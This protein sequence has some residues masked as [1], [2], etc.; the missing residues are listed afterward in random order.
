MFHIFIKIF[1]MKQHVLIKDFKK[2]FKQYNEHIFTI[3]Y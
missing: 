2:A 1:Y 3:K